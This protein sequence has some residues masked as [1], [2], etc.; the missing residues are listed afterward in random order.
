[1][2]G[3]ELGAAIASER[4]RLGMSQRDLIARAGIG[5]AVLPP[6]ETGK[7]TVTVPTLIRIARGLDMRASE[8]LRKIGE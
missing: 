3:A 7:K 5:A 6:L 8:L 2:E 1:M 4:K